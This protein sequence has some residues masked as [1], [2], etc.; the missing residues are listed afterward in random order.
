MSPA[1]D[2]PART[3]EQALRDLVKRTHED[4]QWRFRWNR[5]HNWMKEGE[6]A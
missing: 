4:P 6:T 2:R 3:K 5:Q 1:L